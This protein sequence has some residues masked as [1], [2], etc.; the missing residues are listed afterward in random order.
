MA[1]NAYFNLHLL[2][3]RVTEYLVD[4]YGEMDDGVNRGDETDRLMVTWALASPAAAPEEHD[5]VTTVAVPPDIERLRRADPAEALE[6]RFRVRDAFGGLL[7]D[8][9]S[10]GGY[11][12][13]GYLFVR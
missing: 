4:H 10:V 1:R 8:G 5:V 12:Q 11:D 7:S 2:G 13:R 3:A 6:W 9:F